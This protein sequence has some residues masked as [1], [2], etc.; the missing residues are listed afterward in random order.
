MDE[1]ITRTPLAGLVQAHKRSVLRVL[2]LKE[3]SEREELGA[4]DAIVARAAETAT[5]KR[6]LE[7]EAPTAALAIEKLIHL[8]AHVLAAQLEFD[9]RSLDLIRLEV[10]RIA[11]PSAKVS[12]GRTHEE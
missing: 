6:L 10:A 12:I 4:L 5:R 11:N 3:S 2:E 7:W 8:L 9:D 1:H